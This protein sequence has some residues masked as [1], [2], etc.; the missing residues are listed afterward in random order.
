V[1]ITPYVEHGGDAE[2]RSRRG[3]K[4][5]ALLAGAIL[6]SAIVALVALLSISA[7][8]DGASSV[9]IGT[10]D[11]DRLGGLAL[12]TALGALAV[13][14]CVIPVS[15]VWLIVLAPARIAAIGAVGLAGF[16]WALTSSV[17]VVP[18]TVGGCET[19]YM[20]EEESF[21]LAGRGTVYRQDGLIITAAG[22]FSADD[23]Y[24]PFADG[25]YTVTVSGDSLH[26]WY[27][28]AFDY[29]ATAVSTDRDPDFVL[30]KLGDR[31]LPCRVSTGA[32]S[33]FPAGVSARTER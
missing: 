30:P 29:S 4:I 3:R 7:A 20:V 21:L 24:H 2:S 25:A 12:I 22:R 18:L 31:A 14:L 26:V 17:T 9:L 28:F 16:A 5:A 10:L 15:R 11:S 19:G 13:G 1:A 32:R 27:S 6:C 8:S 33:T 23:G